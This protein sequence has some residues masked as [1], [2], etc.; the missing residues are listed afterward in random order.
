VVRSFIRSF[1]DVLLLVNAS[2]RSSV[3]ESLRFMRRSLNGLCNVANMLVPLNESDVQR[4]SSDLNDPP[5]AA[6]AKGT[7]TMLGTGLASSRTV[8]PALLG[9][10]TVVLTFQRPGSAAILPKRRKAEPAVLTDDG[11]DTVSASG[12]FLKVKDGV[13]SKEKPAEPSASSSVDDDKAFVTLVVDGYNHP[14]T[15]G[16]FV[17]LCMKGFYD[18]LPVAE[19]PFEY[20]G[21]T[22]RRKLFG[23]VAEGYVDP[24]TGL[25]RRIPLEILRDD[26]LAPQGAKAS[27]AG[28]RGS[29]KKGRYTATGLARNSAVFTKAGPVLSFATVCRVG[30]YYHNM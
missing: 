27:T 12:L 16:N 25:Q 19:E 1:Q 21:S 8:L 29:E 23:R 28:Y 13:L 22:V 17:D 5:A 6:A 15:A 3:P 10:A 18:D 20:G 30:L 24:L 9:R 11:T 7:S 4:F 2:R 26:R 14:L